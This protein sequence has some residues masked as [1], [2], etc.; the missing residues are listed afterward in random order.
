MSSLGIIWFILSQ[1]ENMCVL[2]IAEAD[3]K[4]GTGVGVLVQ[5]F[6]TAHFIQLLKVLIR[7]LG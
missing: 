1:F 2:G 7:S 6:N 3:I 4:G 5:Q